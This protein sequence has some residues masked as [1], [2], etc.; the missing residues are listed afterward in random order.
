MATAKKNQNRSG[1]FE[2]PKESASVRLQILRHNQE[3][4]A[5]GGGSGRNQFSGFD[6]SSLF[7]VQTPIQTGNGYHVS[8]A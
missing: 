7:G 8:G 1:K 4:Q 2:E 3:M 5:R 6:I